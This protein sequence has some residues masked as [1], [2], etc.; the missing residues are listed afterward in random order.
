MIDGFESERLLENYREQIRR[1]IV[2]PDYAHE[3]RASYRQNTPSGQELS[4]ADFD[5]LASQLNHERAAESALRRA[6]AW[7]MGGWLGDSDKN[8]TSTDNGWKLLR[9]IAPV[10]TDEEDGQFNAVLVC[11]TPG[12]S[13][14]D[15]LEQGSNKIDEFIDWG[16]EDGMIGAAVNAFHKLFRRRNPDIPLGKIPVLRDDFHISTTGI[17]ENSTSEN[18]QELEGHDAIGHARVGV[19][20]E[21]DR[22]FIGEHKSPDIVSAAVS[23][24][25]AALSQWKT[26]SAS[27]TYEPDPID[28]DQKKKMPARVNGDPT[29]PISLV[30]YK[31]WELAPAK[32]KATVT[33]RFEPPNS[34]EP[35]YVM[36]Y[37]DNGAG[38]VGAG[39]HA[40]NAGARNYLRKHYDGLRS[41][42]TPE[43]TP[44]IFTIGDDFHIFTEG[45]GA[46]ARGVAYVQ[47]RDWK[48]G[49]YMASSISN[50]IVRAAL[51]AYV[52]SING[53][54]HLRAP[55]A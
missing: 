49:T 21:A 16:T 13:L 40:I 15:R 4:D 22:V 27:G 10:P 18:G 8:E 47:S 48:G 55:K 2:D 24:Y 43:K 7:S 32:F 3:L 36:D 6:I 38:M 42:L 46:G 26:N 37:S 53:L 28:H 29:F 45:K 17:T 23:A 50:D 11:D 1:V 20:D 51:D 9:Y 5:Q 33:L 14:K 19:R 34:S 44:R 54:I 41:S 25:I 35:S 31:C 52:K 12:A 39:A 30:A